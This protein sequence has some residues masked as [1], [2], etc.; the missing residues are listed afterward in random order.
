MAIVLILSN[1]GTPYSNNLRMQ[2]PRAKR[3]GDDIRR[4]WSTT[5]TNDLETNVNY[6]L[7]NRKKGNITIEG[8]FYSYR[9]DAG[10]NDDGDV[11]DGTLQAEID[12][13]NID[14]SN[15]D[16]FLS[17]ND[18]GDQIVKTVEEKIA[19]LEEYMFA[20][21][22]APQNRLLGQRFDDQD[23]GKD[24]V[25]EN[26]QANQQNDWTANYTITGRFGQPL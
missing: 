17:T 25:I 18:A 4:D 20:N 2:L 22:P 1:T 11:S 14:V 23:G 19:W 10:V 5:P 8:I 24:I 21:E 26:T 13:G 12:A 7:A 15:D 6:S 3:V 9:E 16:R